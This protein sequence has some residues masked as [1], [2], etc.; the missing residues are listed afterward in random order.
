LLLSGWCP[1]D[2]ID[3]IGQSNHH[4]DP[5]AALLEVLDPEQNWSFKVTALLHLPKPYMQFTHSLAQ[6]HYINV[7]IDLSQVLFICTA[8]TLDTISAPLLDRCEIIQLAGYTSDEK[9]HIAKRFLLP[10]QLE[11][12]GLSAD[13]LALSED[14]LGTITSGYTREA[15]VRSL[16]RA[17]GGVVRF[18]AVEW[19]KSL[20]EE[21]SA[22]EY[23]PAVEEKDLE[24]ILGIQRWDG[25]ERDREER[26][27]VVYGLVVMGQG[28]GGILPVETSALPGNG[29][30]KLTGSL[31]DVSFA[32]FSHDSSA[33]YALTGYQRK[34][35]SCHELGQVECI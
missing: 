14:A 18:K 26:R 8:N 24:K 20:G 11:A 16:E 9:I 5:S 28:E 31:G 29:A 17:I 35:G 34:R 23:S 33:T 12:N 32:S 25:E 13:R 15:G 10:K 22:K 19:A 4:G 27:G 21:G 7:P 1:R 2:E 3:K 30:V 6:D